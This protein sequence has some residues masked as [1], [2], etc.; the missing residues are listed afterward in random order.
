MDKRI[1]PF[2]C[3]EAQVFAKQ[4]AGLKKRLKAVG[5][6]NVVIGLSGGL[7]S[8]LVLL[9]AH[10]AFKALKLDLKGIHLYTMPG[11]GTTRRTKAWAS[12]ARRSA[13]PRRA[14]NTSRISGTTDTS[15]T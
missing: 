10:A 9:V 1:I 3:R 2:P 8:T 15:P 13:S 12:S 11:F 6:K 4:T 7:D 5:C 14:G